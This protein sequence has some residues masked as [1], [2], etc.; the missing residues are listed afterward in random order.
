MSGD[1]DEMPLEWILEVVKLIFSEIVDGI[2]CK[3]AETEDNNTLNISHQHTMQELTTR[4]VQSHHLNYHPIH[5]LQ[6]SVL[7]NTPLFS[8]CT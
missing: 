4:I 6:Y 8:V 3:C 1:V 5:S 2:L 7:L